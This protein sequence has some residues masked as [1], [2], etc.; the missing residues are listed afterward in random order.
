MIHTHYFHQVHALI[1]RSSKFSSHCVGCAASLLDKK[2]G[3]TLKHQFPVASHDHGLRKQGR[4]STRV[5]IIQKIGW[6]TRY[7]KCMSW[8]NLSPI[9][10]PWVHSS[11]VGIQPLVSGPLEVCHAPTHTRS[12]AHVHFYLFM[13]SIDNSIIIMLIL[14]CNQRTPEQ[15][16]I[17][18]T[19]FNI[20]DIV[21]Y[22]V[23]DKAG[24][25]ASTCR[26]AMLPLI[27]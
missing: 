14:I 11:V 20:E 5:V 27:S 17:M 24:S 1:S 4:L 10:Q 16:T 25:S 7:A 13:Q 26:P 19:E 18:F 8:A 6:F 21:I 23:A 2:L 12:L 22:T 9:T 3:T 15:Y